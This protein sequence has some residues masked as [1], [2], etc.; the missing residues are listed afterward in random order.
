MITLY[1]Q[2]FK[3]HVLFVCF[4]FNTGEVSIDLL[5]AGYL[6][7]GCFCIFVSCFSQL[8]FVSCYNNVF[9]LNIFL[10]RERKKEQQQQNV[11]ECI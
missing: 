2:S 4:F 9:I 7:L 8:V 11:I 1:K 10:R 3:S 5:M 6:R